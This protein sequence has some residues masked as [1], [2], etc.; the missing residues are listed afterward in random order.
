LAIILGSVLLQHWRQRRGAV[1]AAHNLRWTGYVRFALVTLAILCL[2]ACAIAFTPGTAPM[3][4][5]GN[6][7]D[8]DHS[9][10]REEVKKEQT[11]AHWTPAF[12]LSVVVGGEPMDAGSLPKPP[13]PVVMLK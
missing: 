12:G 6:F 7:Q 11:G 9:A 2:S 4:P 8:T 5:P 3:P 1:V 10:I 13:V